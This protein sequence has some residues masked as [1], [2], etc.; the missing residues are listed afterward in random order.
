MQ[1]IFFDLDIYSYQ[2]D[3][4]GHVNNAV[5]IQWMEIGRTKLLEAVG[6][7]THEIFQQGF[8]PVLV[9]TSITYKSSLCLGDRAQ[10]ELWLSEL[11]NAS[12]TMQFRFHNSQQT[13]AAEGIQKGLFVDRQ[14]MRPRR[15][16]PE[17]RALFVPY[18]DVSAEAHP[19]I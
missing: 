12:A 13:L 19:S 9:H 10:V 2:I 7:P 11:R 8:A 6:M 1:K 14:T 17:E 18:L 5:Y 4:I 16:L 3:F 15:L